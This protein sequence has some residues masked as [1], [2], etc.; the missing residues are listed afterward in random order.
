LFTHARLR[1]CGEFVVSAKGERPMARTKYNQKLDTPSARARL[2]PGRYWVSVQP[3]CAFGYRKAAKGGVWSAKLVKGK[4]RRE[5]AI[6]AADD[7]LAADGVL[8]LSYAQ[9]QEKAQ[10]WFK[11]AE[12][13]KLVAPVAAPIT[14][15]DALNRYEADLR[16]RG[17][18]AGNVSRARAH[19]TPL[20]AD[21]AVADLT[22]LD[23]RPWR[24]KLAKSLAAATVNRT[25]TV[26]KAALNLVADQDE[27]IANRRAWEIGLATVISIYGGVPWHPGHPHPRYRTAP[28]ASIVMSRA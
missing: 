21:K 14:L 11:E 2:A 26:L 13:G 10:A 5:T 8:A 1:L 15:G 27:R 24:D 12:G 25:A 17:G 3:G 16:T 20:L 4:L 7:I 23:L 28:V 18:D 9:A 19:L 6:G 22:P